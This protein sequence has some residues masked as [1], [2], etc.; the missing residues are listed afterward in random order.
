MRMPNILIYVLLSSFLLC[1]FA[2]AY[3]MDGKLRE[4]DISPFRPYDIEVLNDG[5]VYLTYYENAVLQGKLLEFRYMG[6]KPP[7]HEFPLPAQFQTL[8]KAKDNTLWIADIMDRIVHFDPATEMFTSYPLDP[9]V[10]TLPASILNSP[11]MFSP[12]SRLMAM[13]ASLARTTCLVR[14]WWL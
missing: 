2:A 10:F 7:P 14:K 4:F 3:V 1:G 9:T 11:G 12:R 5:T 8:D 13:T 6:E